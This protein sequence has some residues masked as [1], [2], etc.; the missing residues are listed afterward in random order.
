MKIPFQVSVVLLA[1]GQGTRMN[2]STPKQFLP[3]QGKIVAL[4]SFELFASCPE[5]TEI[6]VVCDPVYRDLFPTCSS[7]LVQFALPGIRRQDSV[8]NGFKSTSPH[9]DLICIHDSARPILSRESLTTLLQQ[10]K[11]YGAAALAVPAKNTIKEC[12]PNLFIKRTLDRS[13]LWEMHTPQVATPALLQKGF[14]IVHAYHL[15]VTDDAAIVE[16]TGHPVKLVPDSYDN[17]KITTSEDLS[18]AQMLCQSKSTK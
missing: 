9:A 1:G 7:A 8:F 13:K 16:L 4:H 15:D 2:V 5:I 10:A 17:I 11:C 6:I 14:E 18:V 12:D 3:L